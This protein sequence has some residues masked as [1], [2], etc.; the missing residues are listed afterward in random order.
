MSITRDDVHRLVDAVPENR[1]PAVG[2]LLR[3]EAEPTSE[4]DQASPN[5]IRVFASAGTLS[6]EHDLSDR[7]EE[8]LR[9][10]DGTAA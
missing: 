10:P 3:A 9:T 8:I 1:I 6:A 5:R 7:V 2:E 4:P